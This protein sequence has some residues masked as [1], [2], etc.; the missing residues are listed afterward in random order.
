MDRSPG[1]QWQQTKKTPSSDRNT[2]PPSA[3]LLAAPIHAVFTANPQPPVPSPRNSP[4]YHP[5][6]PGSSPICRRRR[7]RR[8]VLQPDP[9]RRPSSPPLLPPP[10]GQMVTPRVVDLSIHHTSPLSDRPALWWPPGNTTGGG[11]R[12]RRRHRRRR[13][14]RDPVREEKAA[15]EEG[16][17]ALPSPRKACRLRAPRGTS[18]PGSWRERTQP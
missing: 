5:R 16:C 12:E 7:R 9:T 15:G 18:L 11:H 1:S 3:P 13:R 6:L 10:Q 8:S 2:A 4:R 17:R 14:G